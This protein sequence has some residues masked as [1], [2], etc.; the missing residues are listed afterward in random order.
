LNYEEL[1]TEPPF[2]CIIQL[3][4]KVAVRF[5]ITLCPSRDKEELNAKARFNDNGVYSHFR[6]Y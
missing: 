1:T 3:I 6:P 5:L 2:Q 4:G